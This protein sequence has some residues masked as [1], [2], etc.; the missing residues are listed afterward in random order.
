MV[1]SEVCFLARWTGSEAGDGRATYA[2][3][4]YQA[5]KRRHARVDAWN[6]PPLGPAFGSITSIIWYDV[7]APFIFLMLPRRLAP[8]RLVHAAFPE[9][10]LWFPLVKTKKIVTVHDLNP[11]FEKG[12]SLK[13]VVWNLYARL[14]Y[15]VAVRFADHLIAVSKQTKEELESIFHTPKRKMSVIEP[16]IGDIFVPERAVKDS[17]PLIGFVGKLTERKN[18]GFLFSSLRVLATLDS[19]RRWRLAIYGG[20]GTGVSNLKSMAK[21]HNI[22]ERVS[23]N[24][25][26]PGTEMPHVYNMFTVLV[27]PSMHEGFGFPILEAQRCGIPVITLAGSRIPE[28]VTKY[29]LKV[30]SREEVAYLCCKLA[31]DRELYDKV[32]RQ[33]FTHAAG[34]TWDRCAQKT[35]RV[36]EEV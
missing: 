23:F 8:Y 15:S 16:G 24:A 1:R 17:E 21:Q 12:S 34:F 28:E 35:A 7:M 30:K 25:L 10:G 27:H 4:L 36:Y 6:P 14:V 31:Q 19:S 32:S 22:A 20:D 18:A 13:Q 5:L 3:A 33:G 29:A 9:Q 2:K 26:V 11:F